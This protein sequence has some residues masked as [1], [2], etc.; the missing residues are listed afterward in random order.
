MLW[1][2]Q[3]TKHIQVLLLAICFALSEG[4][5]AVCLLRPSKMLS[6]GTSLEVQWLRCHASNAGGA[7]LNPSQGIKTPYAA[8]PLKKKI[9]I[10]GPSNPISKKYL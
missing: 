7:G 2:F 6:L 1:T 3:G 10:S 4:N 9:V 5:L 8:R